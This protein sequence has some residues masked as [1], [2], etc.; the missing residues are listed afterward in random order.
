M[1]ISSRMRV[2]Q[3]VEQKLINEIAISN[4]R[5][6]H[7]VD[8]MKFTEAKMTRQGMPRY[9]INEGLMDIASSLLNVDAVADVV[10]KY[11]IGGI[12][13]MIGFE[14][15]PE[16]PVYGFFENLFEA[17]DYSELTKYF[18]D[19]NCLAIMDLLTEAITE[20]VTEYGAAKI[21]SYFI[22]S[23]G[24]SGFAAGIADKVINSLGG[25]GQ[26]AL[27][28][29]V[30]EVVK[31]LIEEPV[32]KYICDKSLTDILGDYGNGTT[33]GLSD[34]LNLGN[35]GGNFLKDLGGIMGGAAEDG[36]GGLG[37]GGI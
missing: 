26:E 5:L 20:T 2:R 11:I 16:N 21:L 35:K 3:L 22:T 10:K 23:Q 18:G 29:V 19:N 24:A 27:N 32:R 15:G 8:K 7:A 9:S 13:S 14:G 36:L 34:I 31:G 25:V 30:V 4:K 37:I 17:V 6:V 1:T 12:M 33:G 28:E